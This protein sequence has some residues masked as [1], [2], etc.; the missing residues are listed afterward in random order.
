MIESSGGSNGTRRPSNKN[1]APRSF[2]SS[3]PG[4]KRQKSAKETLSACSVYDGRQHLGDVVETTG[5]A[6]A[7]LADGR[8]V[9]HFPNR[10]AATS[11]LIAAAKGGTT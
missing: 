3:D 1:N 7:F 6:D 5:G 11:A 8:D 4:E 2:S 10:N 9:G